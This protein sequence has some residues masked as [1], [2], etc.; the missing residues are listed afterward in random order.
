[1][2]RMSVTTY[3][4]TN[5]RTSVW[6]PGSDISHKSTQEVELVEWVQKSPSGRQKRASK[7]RQNRDGRGRM[8]QVSRT[9]PKP[10]VKLV[11]LAT[12]SS[13][14]PKEDRLPQPPHLADAFDDYMA[15]SRRSPLMRDQWRAEEDARH[16][17][18]SR[19]RTADKFD[20]RPPSPPPVRREHSKD[21]YQG[22][23]GVGTESYRP[24][25]DRE[26]SRESRK[27]KHRRASPSPRRRTKSKQAE[28]KRPRPLPLE[29]RIT[30]PRDQPAIS[31]NKRRRTRSPSLARSDRYVPSSRRHSRSR[32]RLDRRDRRAVGTDRA[33]SPRRHSPARPARP[34]RRP[35]TPA[36]DTYIP[37]HRSRDQSRTPPTRSRRSRHSRSPRQESPP[38]HPRRDRGRNPDRALRDYSR[39]PIRRRSSRS[40][41]PALESRPH[42]KMHSTQ[43][44]QSIMD[45]PN[46]PPSPSRPITQ[47][48]QG[49]HDPMD[50]RPPMRGGYSSHNNMMHQNRPPRPPPVDT[51]HSFGGSPGF[52]T[53]NSSYHGSPQSASP[54]GHRGGWGGQQQFHGPHG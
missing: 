36:F 1:M 18:D 11:Q 23:E 7:W 40:E 20:P 21:R 22:R 32:D 12:D 8:K 33:F 30:H 34:D 10:A 39:S 53:P 44:I 41:S 37:S 45:D 6:I 13:S 27:H 25:R 16:R 50:G 4:C 2:S 29:E 15:R 43:K 24:S 54:F 42:R 31:F 51:R 48:Q 28:P 26:R 47:Y 35:G 5:R 19:H 46:R 14:H 17:P 49:N 52:V 38:H 3:C 9:S